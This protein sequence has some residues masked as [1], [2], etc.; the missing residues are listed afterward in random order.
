V[1][2]GVGHCQRRGGPVEVIRTGY[3][4]FFEPGEDHWHGAAHGRFMTRL[5]MLEVDDEGS[6]ATWASTSPIGS[7]RGR[8]PQAAPLIATRDGTTA[9]TIGV[10]PGVRPGHT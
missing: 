3:R 7:T 6:S 8:R 2:E 5:A 10:R 1:T 9:A 4:V